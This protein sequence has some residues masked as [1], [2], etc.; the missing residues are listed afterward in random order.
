[1]RLFIIMLLFVGAAMAFTVKPDYYGVQDT[2][3]ET[4]PTMDIDIT[5]DCD[6][7]D[8][9][10]SAGED[11]TPILGADA[12]LFYTDYGYQP[13][14]GGGKTDADGMVTISVTGT[15]DFLTGLFIL[16]TDHS[17]YQSREIEFSYE[18]C[19]GEPGPGEEPEEPEEE[20]ETPVLKQLSIE[21]VPECDG[22]S[23]TG[24]VVTVTSD[25]MPVSGVYVDVEDLDPLKKIKSGNTDDQGRFTF[26]G[27][28]DEYS[29]RASKG[30]YESKEMNITLTVCDGCVEPEEPEGEAMPPENVT[31]P[32]GTEAPEGP[33]EEPAGEEPAEASV[34]PLGALLLSLLVFRAKV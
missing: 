2:G 26:P 27:C 25:G 17:D 20:P 14:P 22:T 18:K 7:K 30:G 28:G 13:L 12:V 32:E 31:P 29:I 6:T 5:I 3:S 8:L 23:V 10:V 19:F 21:V 9:I 34:C 1:M 11:G 4:K 33:A 24:N 16:R 15:L